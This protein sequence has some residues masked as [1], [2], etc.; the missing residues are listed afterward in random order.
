[1]SGG[2]FTGTTQNDG[3]APSLYRL[4]QEPEQTGGEEAVM[5]VAR[6]ILMSAMLTV[7]IVEATKPSAP[8]VV[9]GKAP[10]AAVPVSPAA[11]STCTGVA[12]PYLPEACLRPGSAASDPSVGF[13]STLTWV[14][15]SG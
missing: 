9:A 15:G 12:W 6:V 5:M 4:S 2:E 14:S 8:H 3:H 13:S 1:M 7:G 11:D 10:A